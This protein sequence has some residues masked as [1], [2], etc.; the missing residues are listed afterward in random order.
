MKLIGIIFVVAGLV[1]AFIA[2]NMKTTVTTGGETIGSGVFSVYVEKSEVHNLGLMETRRNHLM[3][4][5]LSIVVGVVM[6]GFG[7]LAG[8]GG[9]RNLRKCPVCA[10]SIQPDAKK[11]HF[12]S[13]DLPELWSQATVPETPPPPAQDDNG[14]MVVRLCKSCRATN[15]GNASA[16]TRCGASLAV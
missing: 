9:G 7:S 15:H 8:Q 14:R 11:C 4:A 5:G 1:W 10:E 13:S 12:C 16:C 2:Y 3:F 6:F